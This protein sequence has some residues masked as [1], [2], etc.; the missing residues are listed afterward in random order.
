MAMRRRSRASSKLANARSRKPAARKRASGTKSTR[1]RS[2]AVASPHSEAAR[3]ASELSAMGGILRLIANSPS[4]VTAV[5]QSVAEQAAQ[6]CQAQYVDIFIVKN[7]TLRNLAW[8]GEI[9][10]T[11]AFPLDRF[12]VSGRSV[13]DMRTVSVDDLQ[14]AGDEFARGREIARRGGHRSIVGV[15]L[16]REG[17]AVGTIVVSRTEIRPFERNH[18]DLLTNFAAQAVIAI[19]NAR[20]LNELRES[21]QQQTATS[22]VLGV[23]SSSPGEL[24]PVFQAMLE[25]AVRIC[26]AK[27]GVLYL[28]EGDGFRVAAMRNAPPAYAELRRREPVMRP[29]PRT[30]IGRA[31]ATKQTVQIA[32][33]QAE[34]GYFDPLPGFSGTQ[35]PA[36]T[37][38]RTIIAVP[39]LKDDSLIGVIIIYRQEVRPFTDKQIALVQNFAA[40]AVIAI[41]NTRLLNELR[42]SLQ[43]Q[44][45]TADVLRIISSSPGELQ[46]VFQ[47]M[48]E[49]ATRICGANF[50]N[51]LLYKDGAF[52]RAALFGAPPAWR[53]D[54]FR[55]PVIRPNEINPIFRIIKTKEVLIIPD[56]ATEQAYL[57]RDAAVVA[58]VEK[59]GARSIIGVPMLKE[60]ELERIPVT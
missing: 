60:S 15:P 57:K 19:E 7:D 1:P 51:L 11:L 29:N 49:N 55:D 37:G 46:P 14:N 58:V 30:A 6:I 52:R 34:P 8:F 9:K 22:E 44:T 56:L 2:S 59:A 16:I 26:E 32:D 48:L 43:Q 33:V 31:A 41:E 13:C 28:S 5:L 36:L 4:N 20:L 18:I 40:Q 24:E 39:M 23:I 53:E 21:L 47:A 10:R 42:E 50:A 45:A 17:R 25:N 54:A 38:A 27:F 12:S 35:M 3:L